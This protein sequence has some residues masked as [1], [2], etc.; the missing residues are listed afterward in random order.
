V[1][2]LVLGAQIRQVSE[3]DGDNPPAA[4]VV[5]NPEGLNEDLVA[6]GEVAGRVVLVADTDHAAVVIE[7]EVVARI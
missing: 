1:F 3:E 6:L 4:I 5:P 7:L 2:P